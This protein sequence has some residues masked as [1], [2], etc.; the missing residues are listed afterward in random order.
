MEVRG[1]PVGVGSLPPGGP[2][3][4]NSAVRLGGVHLF[5]AKPLCRPSNRIT[6]ELLCDSGGRL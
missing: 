5:S 3:E 1:Q 2:G 4:S 6:T